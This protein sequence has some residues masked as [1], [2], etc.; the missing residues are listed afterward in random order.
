MYEQRAAPR[1]EHDRPLQHQHHLFEGSDRAKRTRATDCHLTDQ[2]CVRKQS[3][4]RHV[5]TQFQA[6]SSVDAQEL[7]GESDACLRVLGAAHDRLR[8]R[9]H[10]PESCRPT[11][12]VIPAKA[13]SSAAFGERLSAWEQTFPKSGPGIW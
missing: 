9:D 1:V 5:N 2:T 6:H 8:A 7:R 10:D 4:K 12:K 13:S 3:S 11:Q